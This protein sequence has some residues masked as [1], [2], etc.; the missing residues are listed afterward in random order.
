MKYLFCL[1][2]GLCVFDALQAQQISRKE[3]RRLAKKGILR[4][5][6]LTQPQRDSVEIG[7]LS[8]LDTLR[9]RIKPGDHLRVRSF[10]STSSLFPTPTAA[11]VAV[12]PT[13]NPKDPLEVRVDPNGMA[14]FPQIGRLK[15]TGL[16]KQECATLLEKQYGDIIQNPIVEVD[17]TN[18]KVQVLGGVNRQGSFPIEDEKYTLGQVIA[19]AGGVDFT[20]ADKKFKILRSAKNGRQYQFTYDIRDLSDPRITNLP[21]FDNDIVFVP[22]SKG[23][24]RNVTNQRR[25]TFLTP[26]AILINSVA[27]LVTV[28]VALR[29]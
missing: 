18:L 22:P 9:Y 25:N 17:I 16:T 28:I 27:I 24:L 11:G 10:N 13:G 19:L 23:A 14:V 29:K 3:A 12:M 21:I 4:G 6:S 15:V 1:L 8:R 20:V 2:I 7:L 26:I 5:D